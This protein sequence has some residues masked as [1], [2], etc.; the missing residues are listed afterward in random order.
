MIQIAPR[1]EVTASARATW[2]KWAAD[3]IDAI[4]QE[5]V[6]AIRQ[7]KI[8][9]YA[10]GMLRADAIINERDELRAGMKYEIARISRMP[11]K[12]LSA[13]TVTNY[14]TISTQDCLVILTNDLVVTATATSTRLGHRAGDQWDAGPYAIYIPQ[15]VF[16]G[17]WNNIHFIPMRAPTA[18]ARLPHHTSRSPGGNSDTH[19]PPQFGQ[20]TC[21]GDGTGG[22]G[23][24]ISSL[25]NGFDVSGLIQL[26]MQYAQSY[27]PNSPLVSSGPVSCSH[28]KRILA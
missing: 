4:V 27:N 5:P 25:A 22:Y 10:T 28:M 2:K 8:Q 14:S 18:Y 6:S 19:T 9:N 23:P 26:L 20:Y 7:R 13:E 1:L 17:M 21:W 3:F 24:I 12:R 16:Q 11:I 15:M